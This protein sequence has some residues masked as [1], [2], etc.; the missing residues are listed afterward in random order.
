MQL[1]I[2]ASLLNVGNLDRSIEFCRDVFEL[3]LVARDDRLPR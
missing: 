3:R 1:S 2:Q